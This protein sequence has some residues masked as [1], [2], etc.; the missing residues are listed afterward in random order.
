MNEFSHKITGRGIIDAPAG[1][2]AAGCGI[3]TPTATTVSEAAVREPCR[4][5][6]AASAAS[7]FA[8]CMSCTGHWQT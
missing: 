5:P 7:G 2:S 8:P 4:T 1:C 6:G 3:C